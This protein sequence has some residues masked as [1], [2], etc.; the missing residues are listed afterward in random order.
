MACRDMLPSLKSSFDF[1]EDESITSEKIDETYNLS[2]NE[3]KLVVSRNTF[4]NKEIT[5]NI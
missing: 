2:N 5:H 4:F 3:I 1:N